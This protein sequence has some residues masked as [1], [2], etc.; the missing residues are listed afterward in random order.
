MKE[1]R[2][3]I[4]EFGRIVLPKG[5]R[6]EL[7]IKP[8]DILTVSVQGDSIVLT[9]NKVASGPVRRGKALLFSTVCDESLSRETVDQVLAETRTTEYYD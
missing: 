6:E 3:K 2:V 9:P 1:L 4:D 7:A 5:V 8:G